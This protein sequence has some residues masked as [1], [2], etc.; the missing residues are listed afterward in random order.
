MEFWRKAVL[1]LRTTVALWRQAVPLKQTNAADLHALL[2]HY[3]RKAVP[4]ETEIR[5]Q[6]KSQ[7][8]INDKQ[9]LEST[10]AHTDEDDSTTR[11]EFPGLKKNRYS[12]LLYNYDEGPPKVHKDCAR[13]TTTTTT[14]TTTTTRRQRRRRQ[15]Q[16]R[17]SEPWRRGREGAV[18]ASGWQRPPAVT[19]PAAYS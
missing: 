13:T 6:T 2:S 19:W 11:S 7:C 14:N 10:A 15:R 1:Q 17:A 5:T 3:C 4:W 18:P 12:S 16:R 9:T 8:S